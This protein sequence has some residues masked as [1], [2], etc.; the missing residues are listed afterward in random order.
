MEKPESG[1][2]GTEKIATKPREYEEKKIK[3]KNQLQ[4]SLV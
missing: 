1:R 4:F 2:L 3:F